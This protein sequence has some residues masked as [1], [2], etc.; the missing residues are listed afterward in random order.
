MNVLLTSAGRRNYLINFFREALQGKG[1]VFAADSSAEAPALQ[2]ADKAFVVPLASDSEYIE[3]VLQVCRQNKV[4]LLVSLNDLELPV[5]AKHRHLFLS[6]GTIP[7][8][9]SSEIIN[10]C[11]DKWETHN[12]LR[13][14]G[15]NSPKTYLSLHDAQKALLSGAL[16]FPV[17]VKP[18]WGTAS[19]GIEFAHDLEELEL[20][21][22]VS[23]L[24]LKRSFL[25]EVSSST[26]EHYLLIQEHLQGDEYGLDI[27][28]D[29]NGSY[30]TTVVKRKLVMRAGETDR[31]IT[32]VNG[33]LSAAG[34][35]VGKLLGHVGNLDCDVFVNTS[36][37]SFLEM[38]PRFGGGYLFSHIAGLNL[39]AALISWA[40]CEV[41]CPE[42]FTIETN[43]ASAKCDRIVR[44]KSNN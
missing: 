37:I 32:V 23:S 8:I 15:L 30:V 3:K 21:Y 24:R 4:G 20:A 39:P 43:V 42:W 18:R 6:N 25:A 34:E 9:S 44:I 41:P 27:I 14:I 38:N 5:I 17:V 22:R 28:N 36:G 29:I 1:H 12:F 10:T 19:I 2:E 13:S 11:F 16:S 26:P 7:V 35:T 31:A 40:R 33:H